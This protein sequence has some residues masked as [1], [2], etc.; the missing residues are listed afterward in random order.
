MAPSLANRSL[1]G[2]I[3][4]DVGP[5]QESDGRPYA[6]PKQ[7]AKQL[8]PPG[9]G[10]SARRRIAAALSGAG[11][12]DALYRDAMS[13]I[14]EGGLTGRMQV[15]EPSRPCCRTPGR[16]C[17]RRTRACSQ[18]SFEACLTADREPSAECSGDPRDPYGHHP[19]GERVDHAEELLEEALSWIGPCGAR[20]AQWRLRFSYGPWCVATLWR[21]QKTLRRSAEELAS[22]QGLSPQE[23]AA[24]TCSSRSGNEFIVPR[25][26]SREPKCSAVR[27]STASC[28][29][30]RRRSGPSSRGTADTCAD[31]VAGVA[32]AGL[33]ATVLKTC[34]LGLTLRSIG[35]LRL[36]WSRS[37]DCWYAELSS[38]RRIQAAGWRSAP[39]PLSR[40]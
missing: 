39:S 15:S 36:R 3:D 4:A 26:W 11:E 20:C 19:A 34:S 6:R 24:A 40:R 1:R 23:H 35:C 33:S 10:L 28:S 17:G 37:S 9:N 29:T 18:V 25:R 7:R 13:V 16:T 38:F 21:P 12:L 14:G 5:P 27:M 31:G 22:M 8:G 32:A 2:V 30:S